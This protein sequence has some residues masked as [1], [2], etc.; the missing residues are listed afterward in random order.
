[1]SRLQ[2][3]IAV[4]TSSSYFLHW[5]NAAVHFVVNFT[6][7]LVSVEMSQLF[8]IS[9]TVANVDLVQQTQASDPFFF[10]HALVR[11]V[12]VFMAA[13]HLATSVAFGWVRLDVSQAAWMDTSHFSSVS[14]R[15]FSCLAPALVV[16]P[17]QE[18]REE[19]PPAF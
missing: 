13:L 6:N 3:W 17:R 8:T 11:F 14:V 1:V 7:C 19:F 15:F 2:A 9:A 16:F 10:K 4:P 12:K 18:G 5:L